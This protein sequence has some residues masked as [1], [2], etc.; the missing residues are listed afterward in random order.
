M[1]P[2]ADKPRPVVFMFAGGGAQ[3][4][5]MAADLHKGEPASAPRWT[6]A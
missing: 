2:A 3:Y 5:N 1:V 4:V 6:S